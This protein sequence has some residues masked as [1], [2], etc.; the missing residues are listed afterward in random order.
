MVI[1]ASYGRS[2]ARILLL[3]EEVTGVLSLSNGP[4]LDIH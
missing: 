3:S 1:R 2:A 4:G